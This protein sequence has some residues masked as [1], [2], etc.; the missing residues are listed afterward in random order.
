MDNADKFIAQIA[1]AAQAAQRTSGIPASFHIA[2]AALESAWGTRAI[3]CNLF[4]VK[5]DPSWGTKP[6][7]MVPTHEHIN[8][9][10]V[11]ITAA[12][13][14]YA[15]WD[16]SFA[17]HIKFYKRNPRYAPCFRET[18]PEGWAHAV[19]VAGYSTDPN[20]AKVLCDIING[21]KLK[22]FDV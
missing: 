11:A 13:R 3:G 20:Y 2:Q 16:E 15:S 21:R 17:D 6:V 12:F 10:Y 4:G 14:C 1:P 8:G 19:Q 9:R 18:T 5:A 7:T 22:R